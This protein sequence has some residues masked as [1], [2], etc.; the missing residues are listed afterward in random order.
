MVKERLRVTLFWL[1]FGTVPAACFIAG[2]R[3]EFF[4]PLLLG[5][6]GLLLWLRPRSE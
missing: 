3:P 1:V 2:A 5:Y 6:G 4:W